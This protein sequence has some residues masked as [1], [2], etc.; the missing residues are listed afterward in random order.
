MERIETDVVVVGGGGSGLTAALVA[1]RHGRRVLVLEKADK[2]GGTTARSVGSITA[3][4][5][6][7]QKA[8]GIEDDPDA[9]FE[10][11]ALFAGPKANRDNLELRRLLVDNSPGTIAFLMDLGVEFFGPMPEPPHRKPRMHNILPHSRAY[12]HHLLRHCRMAGVDVRVSSPATGLLN[13]NGR[14]AG[15][16]A[17]TPNGALEV[18]ARRGVVLA[19]GDYS[20]SQEM[21]AELA[22][23]ELADIEGV[24]P[25]STGDGQRLAM[26]AGASVLNG[27]LIWGPEIHFVPPSRPALPALIPPNQAFGKLVK[28]SM[29][30]LPDRVLRPFLMSFVTTYLA[31]SHNLFEKGAILVNRDG[32]RFCDERNS[33]QFRIPGQ[34]DRLAWL[35]LDAKVAR[36]F[37]SWPNFISTAPGVAYA[38]LADYLK[39][40]RDITFRAPTLEG[41]AAKAGVDGTGLAR[42]VAEYNAGRERDGRPA[43]DEGPFVI[44][45]PAKSWVLLTEGGVRVDTSLRVLGEDGAPIP[46]LYAAGSTGQGGLLLEGHGHHLGWAFTSGRLAGESVARAAV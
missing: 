41:A 3:T 23:E 2:P 25:N 39:S 28:L 44:I 26:E 46:G 4:Q 45:G 17:T 36:Q 20:S 7:L 38:Y 37:G 14:V 33:P 21:K 12:I 11:M 8:A 5:T 31:P 16:R 40:R 15:V 24:N 1:A 13:D 34:P 19:A 32:A 27:D 10:D 22:S 6:P 30:R 9:H 29:Q 43:L 18:R 35:V 42:T